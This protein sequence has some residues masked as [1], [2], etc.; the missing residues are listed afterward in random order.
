MTALLTTKILAY[1]VGRVLDLHAHS[2]TENVRHTDWDR[3]DAAIL[4]MT[5]SSVACLYH[6]S[7][8]LL[9]GLATEKVLDWT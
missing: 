1:R 5:I 7:N 9:A 3:D 4:Q 6:L 8:L 2:R